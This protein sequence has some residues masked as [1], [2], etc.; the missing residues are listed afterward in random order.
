MHSRS[1]AWNVYPKIACI[2]LTEHQAVFTISQVISWGSVYVCLEVHVAIFFLGWLHSNCSIGPPACECGTTMKYLNKTLELTWWHTM[3]FSIIDRR[4]ADREARNAAR[5]EH[6][7]GPALLRH[8]RRHGLQHGGRT[9]FNFIS[10][11]LVKHAI[12]KN[13]STGC[14]ICSCTWGSIQLT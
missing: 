2:E 1:L 5:D 13:I 12:V 3:Y 4:G 6:R 7:A 11:L 8:L 10:Q 9:K 14:P